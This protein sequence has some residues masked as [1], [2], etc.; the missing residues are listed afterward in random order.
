MIHL[1]NEDVLE[2]LSMDETMESLRIGFRQLA[3]GDA[4]HIPRLEVWSPAA[5]SDTYHC[6]GTMAGTTKHFGVTAIRIKSDVLSWPD[7][8][9]QEKFAVEPGTYCGFILLFS[10]ATGEPL[11]LIN[12]GVI[13]RMR[14]G[15]SAGI[16]AEWFANPGPST[17]GLLGSGDMARVYLEAIALARPLEHVNVFSPTPINRA[18]FAAEMSERL[19]LIITPV[20]SAEEAVRGSQIVATA[21]NSM[22]PTM[23]PGWIMDGATVLCVTRR[24]VGPELV[25]R[26]DRIYQLGAH[27]IG[28]ESEVADMEWPQSAAGGFIAG[29]AE[30]RAILPWKH[31]AEQR[32]FPSL[33]D[34]MRGTE[35]GR[36]T[37]D[38]T[39][40][41]MNTGN[42]G[43]QFAAV[44]ARVLQLA[45]NQGAGSDMAVGQFLQNI[46]D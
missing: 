10:T 25:N 38:E 21:T 17:L 22:G 4:A 37:P 9:R 26:A 16:G 2:L 7:G 6:L 34:V 44:A 36:S 12:D 19:G 42:Q 46:R 14:V 30:E 45:H 28:P 13:Q 32:E 24:E 18:G 23:D 3:D 33:I 40:L 11:G 39:L 20:D 31:T 35:P 43:I 8:K 41:F 1:D 27:S 29:N 5:S 15:G